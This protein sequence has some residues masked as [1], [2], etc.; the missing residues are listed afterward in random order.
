MAARDEAL[1]GCE[2]LIKAH[3][4]N[5]DGNCAACSEAVTYPCDVLTRAEDIADLLHRRMSEQHN[6]LEESHGSR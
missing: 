2:A 5:V 4:P 6:H 3:Q 1:E